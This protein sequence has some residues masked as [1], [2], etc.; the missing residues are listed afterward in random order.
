VF[1]MYI[2]SEEKETLLSLSVACYLLMALWLF[3]WCFSGD[4]CMQRCCMVLLL[5]GRA[6]Q[7]CCMVVHTAGNGV[8]NKANC[9]ATVLHRPQVHHVL[10]PSTMLV[11]CCM[12]LSGDNWL[13]GEDC[14][15]YMCDGH[16]HWVTV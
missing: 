5:S 8:V 10:Y 1:S 14:H 9:G 12:Q 13:E 4:L 16:S 2:I 11:L 3:Q 6:M 7:R 15:D